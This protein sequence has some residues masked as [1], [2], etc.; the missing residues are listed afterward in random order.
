MVWCLTECTSLS[1]TLSLEENAT[2]TQGFLLAR[3][4]EALAILGL[5][6]RIADQIAGVALKIWVDQAALT[7]LYCVSVSE[8][9]SLPTDHTCPW[10][11][12]T[13]LHYKPCALDVYGSAR[14]HYSLLGKPLI[15]LS[16]LY[17]CKWALVGN[18]PRTR[19]HPARWRPHV[20]G[21]VVGYVIPKFFH[22]GCITAALQST[23]DS[24][25]SSLR[26]ST[27]S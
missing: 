14:L 4:W 27:V 22:P 26:C 18:I 12:C 7:G 23:V 10:W 2:S 25:T 11:V 5:L 19:R 9:L 6:N 8:W 24:A 16:L 15:N 13:I 20:R 1:P 3:T 17:A 21:V